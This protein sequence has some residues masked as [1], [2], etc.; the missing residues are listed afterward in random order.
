MA[1]KKK[2]DKKRDWSHYQLA[3]FDFVEHG[4]GNLVVEA[5]SGAGKTTTL[6]E[7]IRRID[8]DNR[9]LLTAFN[10]DIVGV[11]KRKTKDMP[12]IDVST[13]HALGYKMLQRN[14]P[15]VK[16]EIDDFKY[17]SYINTN[18]GRLSRISLPKRM[19]SRYVAN[20]KK[21]VDFGRL[22]LC[23]TVKDLSFIEERYDIE[24]IE[25]E[26]EISLDVMAWGKKHIETID[27]ID[28]IYLPNMLYCKPIGMQYDWVCADEAQDTSIAQREILLKCCKM[29]TR[30]LFFGD[31]NQTI[32]SFAGSDPEAFRTLKEMPNTISLPLSISYRCARNIVGIAKTI[33]P[34]IE[35][36][37]DGR[38]G[39]VLDNVSLDSVKDG[40][41]ILC[42]NNA[43][44]MQIY[45]DFIRMGKKCFIRGKDIGNNLKRM[46]RNTMQDML[47]VNLDK[48][49][50]FVRLYDE[51]FS[52]VNGMIDKYGITYSEAIGSTLAANRA[53]SINALEVLSEGLT[54]A[55][56]LIKRI[57]EIFS[58]RKKID[59]ISLSTIHKAKGLEAD[60]VYIACKS[61]MP[62]S[63]AL[64]DWEKQQELNLI[65][66][67]YTRAKNRLGFIDE[68]EFNSF[69]KN[70]SESEKTMR[71]IEKKVNIALGKERVYGGDVNPYFN[72]EI[73]KH[74]ISHNGE[75]ISK[76]TEKF[77][78][79]YSFKPLT[80]GYSNIAKNRL[81]KIKR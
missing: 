74:V 80:I 75:N 69:M 18:I 37:D 64:K 23:Q 76:K 2:E 41:M 48:D 8:R 16:I 1:R 59:G 29:N 6:M 22:Y 13:L 43:P 34:T 67:A 7:C 66:V 60:N 4:Q 45:I 9:V 54:T 57:D 25:D 42:R 33:V 68:K 19:M 12:N 53:D 51:Y 21:F 56:E 58:D 47:N 15:D 50:V 27:Y 44:L 11:L 35:E 61:L 3:I 79:S 55:D 10:R 77:L 70:K 72:G 39:E 17:M 46:V 30:M 20:I 38:E 52:I 71:F 36:N 24:T 63:L 81:R 40:D 62:S 31:G 28:M 26:K 49:G 73:V 78:D 14:F 5:A 65:Y 32:Y